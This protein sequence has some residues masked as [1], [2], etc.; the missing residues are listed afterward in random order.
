MNH[1]ASTK[2]I[3]ATSANISVRRCWEV[4]FLHAWWQMATGC[5]PSPNPSRSSLLLL[6][7]PLPWNCCLVHYDTFLLDVFNMRFLDA[8]YVRTNYLTDPVG[9][10]YSLGTTRS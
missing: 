9:L 1:T 6:F 8:G 10:K 4:C 3:F 2:P 5:K 7:C